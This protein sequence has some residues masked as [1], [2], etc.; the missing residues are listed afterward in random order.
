VLII[1]LL[2]FFP[3]SYGRKGNGDVEN[4]LFLAKK[5]G[6]DYHWVELEEEYARQQHYVSARESLLLSGGLSGFNSPHTLYGTKEMACYRPIH[7]V[8]YLGSEVFAAAKKGNDELIS[9]VVIDYIENDENKLNYAYNIYETLQRLEIVNEQED[10]SKALE[11]LQSYI[12]TIPVKFSKN[13]IFSSFMF[14]NVLRAVFGVFIKNGMQYA[15][16]RVP[17][18]DDD[19][20]VRLSRTKLSSFYR[21]FLENNLYKRM[22]G[23]RLY[24]AI[25]KRTW[26]E[27]NSLA[28]SK[29]YA[30]S[31]IDNGIGIY[32][33]IL[34]KLLNINPYK[35]KLIDNRSNIAG[36]IYYI[37]KETEINQ[38][39]KKLLENNL[40]I[41]ALVY[42][43]LSKH[44][45]KK[46]IWRK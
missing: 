22:D 37:Q 3:F 13:Q 34:S 1:T 43:A 4:P 28:S 46:I 20:F 26:K 32:K 6:L 10:I 7:L 31:D 12:Q 38:D 42:W 41:N 11:R 24:P 25:I 40:M 23:Q 30:P 17:F 35:G 16:I 44:E 9:Q 18:V 8:G 2:I 15:K 14:E 5:L 29:G 27:L 45:F 36:S 33:M 39:W 19:F 21:Q